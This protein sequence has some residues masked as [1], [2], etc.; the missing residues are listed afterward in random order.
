MDKLNILYTCDNSYLDLTSISIASVI[1]NNK[2][3]EICFFLATESENDK[4]MTEIKE[5]YK[6]NKHVEFKYLDCQKYDGL[7]NSKKLDKWG[8][9]SYYVYW[10][11]Y[12][13]DFLDV[14]YIW[15]LDSDV[16]CVGK[17]DY[18]N[19]DRPVG[20]VLDTAH[21]D[22]NE[23]AHINKDY[24]LYN[25][26]SLF[27]DV[28]KWKENKCG[29]KIVEYLEN[30]QYM[31]ILCDEDIISVALHDD[32]ELIDPKYDYLVGYDYYGIH[33]TF[34]M[35]SLDKKPF[36]GEKEI[37]KAKEDIV[38]YHCLGGVFGRPWEKENFSPIKEEFNKYRTLSAFPKYE[39]EWNRS[40]LFKVEHFLEFLPKNIYNKIHNKAM[41]LYL[42]NKQRNISKLD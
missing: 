42:K 8:S 7:L 30:M 12:A 21:C 9:N 36:Y 17:I 15:Y 31:P 14:D 32:I 19:I 34:E 25:T 2:G 22:F 11:M 16:I 6:G 33:N 10:K 24:Y 27:V 26:G 20:A 40:L 35:Y 1:E 37:E 5:F 23:L 39:K 41:K 18:P 4:K 13:Y 38:F 3:T 28:K 29:R